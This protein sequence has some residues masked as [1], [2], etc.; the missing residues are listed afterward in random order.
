[1]VLPESYKNVSPFTIAGIK[2]NPSVIPVVGC[3]VLGTVMAAAYTIRLALFNPDVTWNSRK[4]N[5]QWNYYEKRNY[6]F[7]QM[8]PF[9]VKSYEHP[10][11]RF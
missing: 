1:M 2:R 8:E 6:K 10:R 9:D 3:I 4:N 5:E 7:L 11:P